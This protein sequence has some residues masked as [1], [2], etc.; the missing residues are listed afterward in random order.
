MA[1]MTD[2]LGRPHSGQVSYPV[3][4]IVVDNV[5]PDELARIK[6]KFPNLHDQPE[7]FWIRQTAPM[8]GKERGFY[9]LP[10]KDDEVLVVFL[11]GSHDVGVIVGALWNGVDKY[12]PEAKDKLPGPSATETGA[13][14]STDT[15]T[16]GS[17][18]L[19]GNDRRF[20]KSRS[21]H[22][23]VFDDTNGAETVQ[24]W[25][26]THKLAFVFDS[27][28]GAIYLTN[29][30]G[31]IHIRTKNDLYLEAGQNVKFKA[32]QKID[33]DSGMDS[34]WNVGA[35]WQLTVTGNAT[36]S[37]N[38][39]FSISAT[40]AL[41]ASG[42]NATVSGSVGATFSGGTSA[43]LSGGGSTTISGGVVRIN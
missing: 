32:G 20:W 15:F 38:S 43:T 28:K 25:D 42:Q 39:N 17:K 16:D 19:S 34:K 22:L 29:N 14:W 13:S 26:K 36:E 3:V 30:Q 7:S 23:F 31:D 40:S 37:A 1:R 9:A 8:A 2:T 4:G 11:Q 10:E 27:V 5:D 12:P 35:N 21:G 33:V 41:S 24:V 18:D 6:V